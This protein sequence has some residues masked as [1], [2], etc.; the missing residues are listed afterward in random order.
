MMRI[1]RSAERGH[2]NFGWLDTYHSFSFG[3]YYDPA[4]MNFRSLRVI[5]EDRIAPGAGFPMHPHRDMEIITYVIDGAVAH[6]DSTGSS[7]VT[8]AG[9]VQ[10]MSAGTGIRHSEFN[11]SQEQ[12]AHLLQIWLLPDREGHEPGYEQKGF[13]REQKRGRLLPIAAPN[14]NVTPDGSALIHQDVRVYA[15]ILD[16]GEQLTHQLESGRHAWV[17]VVRGELLVN[18]E[19]LETGDGAA[20]SHEPSL[21]IQANDARSELLVFDLA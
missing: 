2:L 16:A 19:R 20:I 10:R 11:P 21:R 18:G 13:V 17:Q 1:R 12:P 9:E 6:E 5:N 8:R 7:G 14:A 3:E 15:S 4:H